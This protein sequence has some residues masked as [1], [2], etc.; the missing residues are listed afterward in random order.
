MDLTSANEWIERLRAAWVQGKSQDAAELFTVDATYRAH[1]FRT[2]LYGRGEI[3]SYWS[4][5]TAS[6]ADLE[7]RFGEPLVD[8]DRVAVE[9]WANVTEGGHRQTDCGALVLTFPAAPSGEWLCSELREYWNL[10]DSAIAPPQ[11]WGL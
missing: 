1:P 3:A 5:S 6:Q 10:A 4:E 8:R 7:V 2:P 9:W 11:G